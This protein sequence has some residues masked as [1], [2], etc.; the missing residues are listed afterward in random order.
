MTFSFPGL[1]VATP[2]PKRIKRLAQRR[3]RHNQFAWVQVNGH[4]HQCQLVDI[5]HIGAKLLTNLNFPVGQEVA[6]RFVPNG[7]FAAARIAWQR[8]R[9]AGVTLV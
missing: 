5:S 4:D 8:G 2:R 7:A 1:R 9:F 3:R 6:I